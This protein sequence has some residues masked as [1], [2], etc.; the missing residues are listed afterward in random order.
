VAAVPEA[1]S[2]TIND[3]NKIL[4][5][6]S[7]NNVFIISEYLLNDENVQFFAE[8]PVRF[9]LKTNVVQHYTRPVVR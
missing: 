9:Y 7:Q 2:A 5:D 6:V 8:R 1:I 4:L 3:S